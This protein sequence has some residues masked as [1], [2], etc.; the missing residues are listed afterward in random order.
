LAQAAG[1]NVLAVRTNVIG[2]AEI[3][4]EFR[5]FG[6]VL[7]E[8]LRR[9]LNEIG[10]ELKAAAISKAP[11]L[12]HPDSRWTAGALQQS[13]RDRL[14]ENDKSITETV[15]TGKYYARFLE[16]GVVAHPFAHNR[17][18][19]GGNRERANRL[20]SLRGSG[21]YRVSPRPFMGPA[22]DAL[23]SQIDVALRAAVEGAGEA[24]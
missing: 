5:D 4:A 24:K 17:T 18:G 19:A 23:R 11:R 16:I 3:A 2:D 10:E 20:R 1:L 15:Q 22:M 8:R 6:G 21:Q 9:T 13:I 12:A 14:V 7:R